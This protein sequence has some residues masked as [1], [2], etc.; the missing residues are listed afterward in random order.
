MGSGEDGWVKG[1]FNPKQCWKDSKYGLL[2]WR[3]H[4]MWEEIVVESTQDG[5]IGPDE[6]RKG[7][8]V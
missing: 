6:L 5:M 7:K 1:A 4:R 3:C 2:I 8:V